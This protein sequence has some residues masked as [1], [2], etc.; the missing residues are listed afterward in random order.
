MELG[1]SYSDG[2][3]AV[4]SS[5][6][7]IANSEEYLQCSQTAVVSVNEKHVSLA[8]TSERCQ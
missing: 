3:V 7:A 2:T 4:M 1:S 5:G 6:A 8:S